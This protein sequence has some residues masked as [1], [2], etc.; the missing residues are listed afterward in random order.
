MKGRSEAGEENGKDV[1]REGLKEG[2]IGSLK[3]GRGRMEGRKE[4]RKEGRRE[5]DDIQDMKVCMHVGRKR[6]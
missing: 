4:E 3:R 6:S 5:E 1:V 2:K